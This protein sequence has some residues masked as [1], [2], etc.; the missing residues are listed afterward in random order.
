M[1]GRREDEGSP[2]GRD[3]RVA[4]AVSRFNDRITRRLLQWARDGLARCGVIE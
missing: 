2:D 3:L 1:A 4:V